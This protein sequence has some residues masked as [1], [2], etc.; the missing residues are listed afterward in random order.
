MAASTTL[1]PEQRTERARK[2]G[3]AAQSPETLASRLV[4]DWPELTDAQKHAVRVLLRPIVRN[5]P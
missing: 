4:K 5:T 2:A 1:T 3:Y